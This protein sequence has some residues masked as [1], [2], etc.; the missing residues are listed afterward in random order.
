[1][2]ETEDKEI[3]KFWDRIDNPDKLRFLWIDEE[4]K[5]VDDPFKK[6][7]QF[8]EGLGIPDTTSAFRI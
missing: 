8:W 6:V 4:V 7:S 1:M 3:Y 2:Y 5:M